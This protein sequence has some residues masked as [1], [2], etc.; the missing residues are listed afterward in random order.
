MHYN[1]HNPDAVWVRDPE[2]NQWIECAWM[3]KDA[4]KR[5]FSASIRRNARQVTK[6]YGLLGDS[7]ATELTISLLGA[8]K[9]ERDKQEH[10]E[11]TRESERRLAELS[12]KRLP[13][14]QHVVVNASSPEEDEDDSYEEITMF[15]PTR[16]VK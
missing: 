5:P 15:D 16:A 13:T 11:R 2:T 3:N 8:T 10:E 7:E 6:A 4:F 9:S 1:P 14:P 12:G